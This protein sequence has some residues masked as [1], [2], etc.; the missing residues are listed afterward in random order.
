MPMLSQRLLAG[1]GLR[2]GVAELALI[3]VGVLCALWIEEWRQAQVDRD[4]EQIYLERLALDLDEDLA[5]LEAQ[6]EHTEWR[7]DRAMAAIAFLDAEGLAGTASTLQDFHFAGFINFF[8]HQ[9]ATLDDLLSTGNMRLLRDKDLLRELTGYYRS[10]DFLREFDHN[11]REQVWGY[12]RASLRPYISSL[13]FETLD[14]RV[15][16]ASSA[17][18]ADWPGLRADPKVRWGLEGVVAIARVERRMLQE[19]RADAEA[20]RSRLAAAITGASPADG[21]LP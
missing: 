1:Q 14:R 2:R 17:A 18:T 11:K 16:E 4:V 8:R 12:Y 13:A 19:V 10:T 3:V 7:E 20:L 21:V 15:P 5:S 9:R 6:I